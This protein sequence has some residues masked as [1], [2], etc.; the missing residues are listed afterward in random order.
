M[1]ASLQCPF[2]RSFNC[3]RANGEIFCLECQARSGKVD[4]AVNHEFLWRF[5]SNTSGI[6]ETRIEKLSLA[7]LMKDWDK[8]N[9]VIGDLRELIQY[10]MELKEY[11]SE[12][13][14]EP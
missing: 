6:L 13:S 3:G 4:G 14:S 7:T 2:C 12:I 1:S 5:L 11:V 10:T 8:V 9:K